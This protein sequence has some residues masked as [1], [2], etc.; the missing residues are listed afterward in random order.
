ML[1][2]Q[3]T[4]RSTLIK[5]LRKKINVD[6]K[7]LLS[8]KIIWIK[9]FQSA[10]INFITANLQCSQRPFRR[11]YSTDYSADYSTDPLSQQIFCRSK[12]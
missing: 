4:S 11:F 10:C 1:S 2:K 8:K 5:A 9:Q 6:I 7:K 12:I 3:L